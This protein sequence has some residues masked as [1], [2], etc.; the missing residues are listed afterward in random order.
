[1]EEEEDA[2]WSL[3]LWCHILERVIERKQWMAMHKHYGYC[4]YNYRYHFVVVVVV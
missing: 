1:M 3:F 4:V 2:L